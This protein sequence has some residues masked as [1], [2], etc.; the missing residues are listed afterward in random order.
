MPS[1]E[2]F[3]DPRSA[4]E[5]SQQSGAPV[6][7]R[8]GGIDFEEQLRIATAKIDAHIQSSAAGVSSA[9]GQALVGGIE[10]ATPRF[11]AMLEMFRAQAA[12]GVNIPINF[13][14]TGSLPTGGA[15]PAAAPSPPGRALGGPV[16]AGRLY[17]VGENN[18]SEWFIPGANGSI[19]PNHASGGLGGRSQRIN[20]ALGGITINGGNA[21]DIA[22]QIADQLKTALAG[23]FSDGDET[24]G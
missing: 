15:A 10:S 12:T 24:W 2:G 9:Y 3:R 7:Y 5:I 20:V 16:T 23:A 11:T 17:E 21:S 8:T 4:P 19:I 14:P 18:R 1:P 13:T 6:G 22:E